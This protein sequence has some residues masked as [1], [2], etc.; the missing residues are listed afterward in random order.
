MSGDRQHPWSYLLPFWSKPV[1]SFGLFSLT[2]VAECSHMLSIGF[3][4]IFVSLEAG[5]NIDLT[6][7]ASNQIW[8]HHN[9]HAFLE[10]GNGIPGLMRFSLSNSIYKR[11][12]IALTTGAVQK[13]TARRLS[14]GSNPR[15]DCPSPEAAPWRQVF[16]LLDD[17]FNRLR[18][19]HE[20]YFFIS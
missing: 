4:Q 13:N 17:R 2:T 18:F 9:Q 19:R 3:I 10:S 11:L 1:S 5:E 8:M 16:L 6:G 12:H 14:Q 20:C 15:I 7:R